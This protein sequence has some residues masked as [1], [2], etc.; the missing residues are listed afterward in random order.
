MLE[1]CKSLFSRFISSMKQI[2]LLHL[3][4]TVK[5]NWEQQITSLFSWFHKDSNR[6]SN[7]NNCT[8]SEM[9]HVEVK[10]S[11]RTGKGRKDGEKRNMCQ[12]CP[13]EGTWVSMT[14]DILAVDSE[15]PPLTPYHRG[16]LLTSHC[17]RPSKEWAISSYSITER[18]RLPTSI[19]LTYRSSFSFLG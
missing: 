10:R 2:Q 4:I 17:E 12:T 5:S 7:W 18:S 11:R 9:H 3:N 15:W 13:L 19:I 14:R 8:R 6:T 1:C 16:P